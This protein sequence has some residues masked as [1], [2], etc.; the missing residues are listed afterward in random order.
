MVW[1]EL[2]LKFAYKL[3]N[4]RGIIKKN[5]GHKAVLLQ[6][7]KVRIDQL[8][9]EFIK[10]LTEYE[11]GFWQVGR[12]LILLVCREKKTDRV[13]ITV[14]RFTDKSFDFYSKTIG[15][16]YNVIIKEVRNDEECG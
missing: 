2:E 13:F 8:S 7:F 9:S 10:Y 16:E 15:Q 4:L 11:G 14:R 3:F 12:I 6:V 5:T 1:K